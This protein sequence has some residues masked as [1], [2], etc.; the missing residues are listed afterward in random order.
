[1]KHDTVAQPSGSWHAVASIEQLQH[2]GRMVVK[3]HG[4][5]LALFSHGEAVHACN[6]RCPHEGY[7]LAEGA[8]GP[9]CVLTCHWHNWQFDLRDGSNVH[10]G[11]GL[12]VYPVAQRDGQVWVD[13]SEP[14][15]AVRQQQH[16]AALAQ[17]MADDDLPRIAR[18][19]AR[20]EAAGGTADA[21]LRQG[22][23]QSH[24]RLRYG[25]THAWAAAD[26][27]VRLRDELE[28]PAQRLACLAE[29]LSHIARDTL[30]EPPWP[31]P[32]AQSVAWNAQLFLDRV[33]AQDEAGASAQ[34][35]AGLEQASAQQLDACLT[36]AAL[37]HYNDF[38]HSLIY[39]VH[40]RS[41]V[42]RLGP[43][44]APALW[45]GW[46]RALRFGTREDLLPDF[47]AY[48]PA[49]AQW[50][51]AFGRGNAVPNPQAWFGLAPK[52]ALA[53][54]L[55]HAANCEP[56]ALHE[57]LMCV[58]AMHLAH[59]DTVWQDRSDGPVAD[60][61]GWLDFSHALTFAHAVRVQC[62]MHPHLWP[63]ALA[64]MT[65][66]AARN[67]KYLRAPD[68]A[69]PVGMHVDAALFDA[70]CIARLLDHGLAPHIFPAHLLKTWLAVRDEIRLGVA[71]TT[72]AWLR[73]AVVQLFAARLKQRHVMRNAQQALEI[74]QR[75]G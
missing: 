12:A 37:A 14:A 67:A 8:L 4:K 3:L 26:G 44:V 54:T 61:I 15:P 24:E 50:P 75:G 46:L 34:L 33:E 23:L 49:M 16:L 55:Q 62:V 53:L 73:A 63:A 60:N 68:Q 57:A 31:L 45:Q 19:A 30:R 56:L 18:E 47:R 5:Q 59:F 71:A 25:M 28:P 38:G 20:L 74:V 21:A 32:A 51:A 35:L 70:Q 69:G 66:F 22:I 6:N 58:G 29:A 72:A 13:L 7:P 48:A 65:L 40:V 10:G 17:A 52:A 27:W 42:Q 43:G 64:Q 39:L 2:A 11:D 41:L 36:E 9:D 1:M